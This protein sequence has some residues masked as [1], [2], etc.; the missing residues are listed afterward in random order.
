LFCVA[1]S[2]VHATHE[3]WRDEIHCWSLGRNATGLWELLVGDRRYDGH[4]FLWYYLLHLVSRWSRSEVYL[5]V[6]TIVL[7]TAS[8]FLWLR[9]SR[10]PRALRVMLLGTYCIFFEYSVISRSY[11]LG[12]FLAFLFCRLY[13]PCSLRILRLVVVLVLLSFTSAYGAILAAALG[14]FLFWQTVAQL[15]GL[16]LARRHR[17]KLY[18]QW[19]LG[20]ALAGFA[21]WVHLKTSLPP[22]DALFVKSPGLR[23]GL[24]SPQGF[25]LRFWSVMFP[26]NRHNDGTWIVSGFLG[27]HVPWI[28]H[29]LLALTAALLV[30]WLVALR[31]VPA[32]AFALLVGLVSMAL[33]QTY[34]YAGF[35]RH[36]GHFFVMLVLALWLFEKHSKRRPILLYGL[37]AM[38]LACQ[39]AANARA[40]ASEI[41]EPFSSALDAANFLRSRHLENEPMLGI[42]DHATSPIAGYLDRSFIW[43]E[44]GTAGQTVV[45]HN[46]RHGFATH[47]ELLAWAQGQ[48]HEK[49]RPVLLISS[50]QLEE[51]LPTLQTEL[52]YATKIALR[53]DET[54]AIYRL[55]L[56][57]VE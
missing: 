44:T 46:R 53:A 24:L 13:Q 1:L 47:R 4:P 38:T 41:S 51:G 12:V 14:V 21:L 34:Q 7:A 15:R 35:L 11:A 30:L 23:P 20:M 42:P 54:Y 45:F 8:A 39:I 25:G 33:F 57:P 40:I 55:S 17:R 32:A 36:W 6:V 22:A 43:P 31:Q 49:G 28:K 16:G 18:R 27:D 26:W 56:A 19:L 5:H 29:H 37:V 3:L 10:L 9:D 2:L 50:S 52:L 48:I